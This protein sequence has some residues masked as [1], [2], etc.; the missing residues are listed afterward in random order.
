MAGINRRVKLNNFEWDKKYDVGI[1]QFD[2]QHKQLLTALKDIYK[3]MQDKRDRLALAQIINNL[4][5]YANEHLSIEEA[6]L[7]ENSY[8]EYEEHVRQHE[9]FKEKLEKFCEDFN[10]DKFLLH[11]ELAVFLK[12]WI[13]N[14]I[15]LVDR[16]Y[17]D[18]LNSKGLY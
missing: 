1:K 3:A 9:I 8:P 4:K 13:V 12:N 11:F 6:C 10:S 15:M 18:F 16:K 5:Q 7:L 17:T 14:H 2:E